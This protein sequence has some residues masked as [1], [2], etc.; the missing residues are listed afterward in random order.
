MKKISYCHP[1]VF[2]IFRMYFESKK[3]KKEGR[4]LTIVLRTKNKHRFNFGSVSF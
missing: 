3:R 1:L 2:S 4:N